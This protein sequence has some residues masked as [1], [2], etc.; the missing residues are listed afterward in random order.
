MAASVLFLT[1]H[2]YKP[3]YRAAAGSEESPDSTGQRT[4]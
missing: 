1:L 2:D 3:G 4:T